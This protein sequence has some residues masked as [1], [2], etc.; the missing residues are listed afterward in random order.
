VKPWLA[1]YDDDVPQSLAPY[2]DRT[3]VDYL[4]TLA[5]DHADKTALLFKGATVSYGQLDAESNAF[6]AALSSL[7][8]RK[9]DRVALLLPNCPQFLIAQFGAWKIG[10][11]VVGANPTYT[12]R[13]LEGTLDAMRVQTIVTL[14]P[15]YERVKRVQGRVG[16]KHVIATSIKDYLPPVLRAL[17]TLFKERKDG[18]RIRLAAGDLWMSDLLRSH[19]GAARPAVAVGPDDQAVILSSGGTTGTPKGVVGL[20]RHYIAA[21]RQLDEWT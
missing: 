21:G 13:E 2:P 8:V 9:G 3:L 16:L 7:G 14:T 11:V 17:F 6:A 19:S 15:F 1:H 5:R 10:A 18:H 12:E 20:H 4:T